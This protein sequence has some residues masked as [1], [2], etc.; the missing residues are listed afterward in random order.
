MA[1]AIRLVYAGQE[2]FSSGI[3]RFLRQDGVSGA[4]RLTRKEREMLAA[5]AQGRKNH[6]IA[7]EQSITLNTVEFHMRNLFMKLGATSRADAV[8]R[9]QRLGWIDLPATNE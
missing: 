9:A 6:E 1:Q 7:A 2:V 5:V 4:P 3:A 8:M